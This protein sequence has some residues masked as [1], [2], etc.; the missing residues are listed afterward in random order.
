ML[1]DVVEQPGAPGATV[2]EDVDAVI[3][4]VGSL[5]DRFSTLSIDAGFEFSFYFCRLLFGLVVLIAAGM[6]TG[7]AARLQRQ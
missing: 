7:I 6:P 3:V 5:G 1:V 2:R 4:S